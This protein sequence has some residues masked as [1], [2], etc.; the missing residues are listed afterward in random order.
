VDTTATEIAIA[1]IGVLGV[2]A[3]SL[4]AGGV[5]LLTAH[6]DRGRSA[7]AAARLI[8]MDLA[9]AKA[10]L[11]S[12]V[13]KSFWNPYI[14][15]QG[16]HQAW[17]EHRTALA[18]VL[19]TTEFTTVDS[20][21]SGIGHIASIRATFDADPELPKEPMEE[22]VLDLMRTWAP[23]VESASVILWRAS[24]SRR[25]RRH[26]WQRPRFRKR[27]AESKPQDTSPKNNGLL[28]GADVPPAEA[29]PPPA[30]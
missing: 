29:A 3:G 25:E 14:N 9:M 8:Y 21:F 13:T 15:W 12:A 7:R 4:A 22:T 6:L 2:A 20:A 10:A 18:L 5:Q 11:A 24:L 28:N 26:N 1:A 30:D 16:F 19:S 17:S 23:G 27:K